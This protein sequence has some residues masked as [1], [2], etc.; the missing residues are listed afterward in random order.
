[1]PYQRSG[2]RNWWITVKGVRQTSGTEIYEDAEALEHRLNLEDWKQ[3]HMGTKPPKSWKEAV[4]KYLKERQHKP[5]YDTIVQR[6]GWWSPHLKHVHDLRNI[7][8]DMID[9][10]L[11]KHRSVTALPSPGN[12]TANK[13]AG[14]VGAVLTAAC[15]EW[16]WIESTPKLRKYPEP[17]H[18]RC[19]LSVEQWNALEAELP[20]HLLL[21]ARFALAT[22]LR[23]GKVF[24]LE[25]GQIDIKNRSMTFSGNAIKR[26]NTIPLNQT[27][28]SV[29]EDAKSQETVHLQRV[30]LYDGEPLQDYGAAW[31]KARA[32]AGLPDFPWHG[33]RH[34]F[35]SWLGQNGCP[36]TALDQLC[37]WAEKDTRSIYTHLNVETLR[38]YSEIIDIML[39]TKS[40]QPS[41]M[42]VSA[43]A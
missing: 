42:L 38:P 21:P 32:R 19:W 26:G 12:T 24:G 40:A 6:L 8:R 10:I 18:R 22:G 41:K 16:G 3:Q 11:S 39:G 15:R 35:A 23:A 1:M 20:I 14:S 30:F 2:S 4:V 29:L 13:Y 9:S 17:A 43:T 36:E 28:I 7:T 27:A 33:F 5:S 37:G 34:T 31:Y 25:W